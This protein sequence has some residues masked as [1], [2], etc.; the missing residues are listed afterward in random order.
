MS[1]PLRFRYRPKT[2]DE[3]MIKE[4]YFDNCYHLPKQFEPE[5]LVLDIG[6][7]IGSFSLAC[8]ERGCQRL[9]IYEPA[10]ENYRY[11]IQNLRDS[12]PRW[13]LAVWGAIQQAVI[14][15]GGDEPNSRQRFHY[16]GD[17]NSACGHLV[18]HKDEV[19]PTSYFVDTTTFAE[20]VNRALDEM[21]GDMIR[22]CKMDIEGAEIPILMQ[23]DQRHMK[24][25]LAH[26]A[27]LAF[28]YHGDVFEALKLKLEDAGFEDIAI[29]PV[30][31]SI[32]LTQ[33]G[34]LFARHTA[35]LYGKVPEEQSEGPQEPRVIVPNGLICKVIHHGK[36]ERTGVAGDQGD[37][38][39]G[40]ASS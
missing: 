13:P 31:P 36:D 9:L 24:W 12:H 25:A 32:P 40:S 18:D 29:D 15:Y 37:G 39:E 26:I 20:V 17:I 34:L 14:A 38:G 10:I 33:Q 8:L 11:L 6:A 19:T 22:F 35:M 7:H 2:Q 1:H 27:E 5:D 16:T 3:M 23:A 30:H 28:E 4:V 21:D